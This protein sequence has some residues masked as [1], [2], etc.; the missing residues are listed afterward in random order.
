MMMVLGL[1]ASLSL[2]FI[3]MLMV[4]VHHRMWDILMQ[5]LR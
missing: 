1:V 3:A 4:A 2:L 5:D